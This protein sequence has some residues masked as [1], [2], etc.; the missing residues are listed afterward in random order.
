MSTLTELFARDPRDLSTQDLDAI[1]GRYR[2]ARQQFNL[3]D[4]TAGNPKKTKEKPVALSQE[5][6]KAMGLL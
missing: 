4:K 5:E 6:L 1:I 2:E 3:G